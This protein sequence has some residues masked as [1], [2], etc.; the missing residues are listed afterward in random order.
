M[1]NAIK[2]TKIRVNVAYTIAEKIFPY[3]G[4]VIITGSV[5]Y[6]ANHDVRRNSDLDLLIIVESNNIAKIFCPLEKM[7]YKFGEQTLEELEKNEVDCYGVKWN[8]YYGFPIN[9]HFMPQKT[10]TKICSGKNEK[11]L[12]LRNKKKEGVY[13]FRSFEGVE[14]FQEIEYKKQKEANICLVSNII[15][16]GS[17]YFI[18]NFHDKLLSNPEVILSIDRKIEQSIDDLWDYTCMRLVNTLS[19]STKGSVE[20][21]LIRSARF[22]K[23]TKKKI[24]ERTKKGFLRIMRYK[25]ANRF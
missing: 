11:I 22:N 15:E 18:S 14:I 12:M 7:G 19:L 25:N 9:I 10:L 20:N 13:H 23:D 16:K 1:K 6:A 8:S 17:N 3:V 21:A 5:S 24:S 4:A 2:E